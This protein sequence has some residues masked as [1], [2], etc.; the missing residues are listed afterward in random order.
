[1]SDFEFDDKAT[2]GSYADDILSLRLLY[3]CQVVLQLQQLED[4]KISGAL[5]DL[6]YWQVRHPVHFV[7]ILLEVGEEL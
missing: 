7:D 1:L 3:K 5:Q 6:K 4:E 2:F